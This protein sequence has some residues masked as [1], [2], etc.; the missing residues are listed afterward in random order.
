MKVELLW[1]SRLDEGR[2]LT[3]P[4]PAEDGVILRWLRGN[5]CDPWF[6]PDGW[7][8]VRSPLVLIR[9]W[10]EIPLPFVAWRK[11][12]WAGYIGFKVYGVD[13]DAYTQWLPKWE[14]YPGSLA[15]C[16]SF[17]PF[18]LLKK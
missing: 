17:R 2:A 18:A 10:S 1:R 16:F 6:D 3:E 15:M 4:F 14:V 7:F 5:V 9:F 11:G 8:G 12:R 13:S